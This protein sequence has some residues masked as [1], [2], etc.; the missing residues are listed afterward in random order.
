MRT[1]IRIALVLLAGLLIAGICW[2]LLSSP[3]ETTVGQPAPPTKGTDADGVV[4]QLSDYRG[5][6]VMLDFWAEWC[7]HCRTMYNHDK[8]LVQRY[9]K[10]PFA[11]LGVN[12]DPDVATLKEVQERRSLNWRSWFDGP[13]QGP[14][15]QLWKVQGFPTIY[16]IDAKGSIRYTNLARL[17]RSS[18]TPKSRSWSRKRRNKRGRGRIAER[19][20]LFGFTEKPCALHRGCLTS[21]LPAAYRRPDRGRRSTS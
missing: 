7:P 1:T 19:I 17:P 13:P 3:S 6:V 16:L 18:W 2:V 20:T 8:S 12:V 11:L 21:P 9:E 14:I 15:C 4:F 5:K 10:R